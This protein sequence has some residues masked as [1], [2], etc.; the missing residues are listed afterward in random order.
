MY[1]IMHAKIDKMLNVIKDEQ[2]ETRLRT[3]INSLSNTVK[4]PCLL[5]PKWI[6]K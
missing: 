5:Q 4:S 6:I 2:T 1:P 3:V